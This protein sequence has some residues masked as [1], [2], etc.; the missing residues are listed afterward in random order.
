ML[1]CSIRAIVRSGEDIYRELGLKDEALSA[2]EL[3]DV[4]AANPRLLE[5]PIVVHR[6]KA[7]LGR[8]PEKVL[9]RLRV[10]FATATDSPA[11]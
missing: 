7:A 10:I 2:E 1:G 4:V 8:P 3:L 11:K 5:R 6:G 9:P